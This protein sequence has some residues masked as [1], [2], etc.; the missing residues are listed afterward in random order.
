M[1]EIILVNFGLVVRGPSWRDL[2]ELGLCRRVVRL[3]WRE[4]CALI[5]KGMMILKSQDPR[6]VIGRGEEKK[7]RPKLLDTGVGCGCLY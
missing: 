6:K 1:F 4:L 5:L 2:T 7:K 3:L